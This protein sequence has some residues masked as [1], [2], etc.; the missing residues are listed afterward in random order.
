MIVAGPVSSF[1]LECLLGI[2]DFSADV[3]KIALYANAASLDTATTTYATA[4]EVSGSGY[5]PGG[6]VIAVAPTFPKLVTLAGFARAVVDFAPAIWPLVTLTARA[7][8]IYNATKASR[9]VAVLDFGLDRVASNGPFTVRTP[10]SSPH[11][12]TL[13]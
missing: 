4:D 10:A 8:L 13:N 12:I 11:L 6:I 7:G 9:A 1:K 2:H 5:A 3:F